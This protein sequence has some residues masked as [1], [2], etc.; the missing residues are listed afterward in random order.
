MTEEIGSKPSN[1][2]KPIP[3]QIRGRLGVFAITMM[4]VAGAAPAATTAATFPLIYSASGSTG[5]PLFFTLTGVLLVLFAVG[6][7]AMSKYI[8]NAGAFYSYVQV[9][10][11][12]IPGV[13]AAFT[14]LFSYLMLLIGSLI[15]LGIST[16]NLLEHFAVASL[17]WWVWA[18]IALV[19]IGVLGRQ[20]IDLSAK[21][22]GV[23]LILET[24]IVVV[25]DVGIIAQGGA[26]GLSLEPYSP[27]HVLEGTP[28]LGLLFAFL[29]YIGFEATA[30]YRNEAKDH[31]RTVPRAT[32]LAVISIGVFYSV[33]SWA[34]AMGWGV[35]SIVKEATSNPANLFFDLADRF[36]APITSD[37]MQVLVVGSF[38]A[39]ALNNHNVFS[40]YL[41]TLSQLRVLP[42]SLAKVSVKHGSP[43][44]A[45]TFASI[46]GL[47]AIL[48]CIASQGDP[49]KVFGWLAGA[50]TLGVVALVTV[51][52]LS[53]IVFFRRTANEYAVWRTLVAPAV[54]FVGLFVL[55]I[56]T[57]INFPILVGDI[58]AAWITSAIVGAFFVAGCV[59]ALYMRSNSRANYM[60]LIEL[61]EDEP[62][63]DPDPAL[64]P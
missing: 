55:L 40:R 22:L 46:I 53:V 18:L 19:V 44:T 23:V 59:R 9:G 5:A 8:K 49:L 16:T 11:G 54:A 20:N 31:E 58:T 34:E 15:Y 6:F 4:V 63:L 14:A 24:L 43:Q 29:G 51:T 47:V 61:N 21:A 35:D 37:I 64:N 12:R 52:S 38:F 50:G 30:V 28:A 1:G 26:G 10:L 2:A 33:S 32:Y 45:S 56:L 36:V 62:R 25:V 39:T 57:I 27:S 60:S 42:K 3:T 13:G 41:Y 48:A 17:P 7:T